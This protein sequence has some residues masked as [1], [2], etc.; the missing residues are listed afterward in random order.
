[1]QDGGS[2]LVFGSSM[3]I[4]VDDFVAPV[5]HDE[6]EILY[7]DQDILLVNKPSKLLSLSGKNPLNK[8][9]VHYRLVQDF[10][11]ATLLHRLDLGT[12]G[13]MLL[14]LNKVANGTLTKQFQDRTTEKSYIAVLDGLLTDDE[15][16]ID[17]PIA[18]DPPNFPLMKICEQTGNVARTKFL[19]LERDL[20]EKSTR[21]R[22]E[23]ITGRTHQ[24]RIHSQQ[25]GYPILGCDLY[26]N[27]AIFNKANRLMLH[28]ESL[29]FDHPATG[30]RTH[31]YA[32]C[33]F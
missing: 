28:A 3:S 6:I 15:G 10:P 16:V 27:E 29:W 7:Q 30:E 32:P 13:V 14:A 1:M 17:L 25:I 8:D 23:P 33:P 11:T 21:V 4:K 2:R 26:S 22:F 5:C 24:L 9:S 19:V 31:A 20:L 12:S 18:K